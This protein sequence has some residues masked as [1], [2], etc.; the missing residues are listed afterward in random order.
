MKPDKDDETWEE[1]LE[2]L[3]KE[4]DW[5]ACPPV[6]TSKWRPVINE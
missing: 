5:I 2:G 3:Q 6:D 1:F 4:L